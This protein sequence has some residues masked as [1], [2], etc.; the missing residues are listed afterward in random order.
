MNTNSTKVIKDLKEKFILV[1]REL[2]AP[3][4]IVWKAF[5]E[6]EILDRWWAPAPWRAETK[7]QDFSVGGYWL[8]AMVSPENEKHW[9]RLNYL[10]IDLHKNFHLED[11]FCDADGNINPELPVSKGSNT[12]TATSNGTLV[13]FK[14]NYSSEEQLQKL[15]EMGFEKGI[16]ACFEQLSQL[17]ANSNS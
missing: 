5:T 1:S 13:E 8:Y 11:A 3:V 10:S 6:S 7:F 4:E 17:L 12:F 16:V 14:M 15:I 2:N 9:G